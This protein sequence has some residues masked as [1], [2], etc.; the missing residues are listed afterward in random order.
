M[1]ELPLLNTINRAFILLDKIVVLAKIQLYKKINCLLFYFAALVYLGVFANLFTLGSQQARYI[2]YFLRTPLVLFSPFTKY[3]KSNRSFALKQKRYNN[4]VRRSL[5]PSYDAPLSNEEFY[6]WFVGFSDAESS[7]GIFPLLNNKKT[8]V[9]AFSFKFTI[10]L[11][12]DDLDV[13][14]YIKSKLGFGK[15]YQN[16]DSQTF[17]VTKKEDIKK[18]ISIFY[19]YK[20]NTTKYLDYLDL[21]EAFN[22]YHER[23]GNLT[24]ELTTQILKLKNNMNTN[25]SNFN[26]SEN[27]IVITKSWLLGF[28]EGDGSFSLE[29]SSLVPVFSILS[30]E[31]Q[32]PVLMKIKEFLKNNLGFDLYSLHKLE[33]SSSVFTISTGK[34][35]K[36][37]K[38]LACCFQIKNI[39]VLNNYLVPFFSEGFGLGKRF[40][41]FY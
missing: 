13:L 9:E 11:H 4:L 7:F 16:G 12:N 38:P 15:I 19:K 33:C 36:N 32:L 14:N 40:S 2:T 34:A 29:R 28:L 3:F 20:L 21:K 22:L 1:F 6:R 30:T 31:K 5:I 17:I 10:G 35:I 8:K 18:L 37:S 26:M 27:H 25:R 39:H 23:G 41:R 24:E